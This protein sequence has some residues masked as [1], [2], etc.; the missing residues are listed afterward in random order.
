[1]QTQVP[2]IYAFQTATPVL[3]G[4]EGCSLSPP[5]ISIIDCSL[6]S[7]VIEAIHLHGSS[8]HCMGGSGHQCRQTCCVQPYFFGDGSEL[9]LFYN[10]QTLFDRD[11][12]FPSNI[13]CLV[14]MLGK[15]FHCLLEVLISRNGQKGRNS[16]LQEIL[17]FLHL[18]SS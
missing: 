15:M 7:D 10:N 9:C 8:L 18:F 4:H 14:I 2:E 17:L 13:F 3:V 16:S 12:Y 6:P 11:K 1:M 5:S